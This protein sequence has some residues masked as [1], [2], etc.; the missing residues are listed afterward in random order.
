MK[1]NRYVKAVIY[2]LLNTRLF[3]SLLNVVSP[4]LITVK[5]FN[6]K[7]SNNTKSPFLVAI[8]VDTESGFVN[9]NESRL[10]AN[11]NPKAFQG[12]YHGTNNWREIAKGNDIKITF[13]LCT[14]CFNSEGNE[15]E[16]IIKQLKQAYREG[17][18]IGFHLH[19]KNDYALQKYLDKSL[20]YTSARF[21]DYESMKEML[22]AGRELI[23]ENLGDEIADNV[24]SFRWGNWGL[25]SSAVKALQDTGYKVDTSAC[26]QIKGHQNGEMFYDWSNVDYRYPWI[27]S[28]EDYQSIKEQNSSVIELPIATFKFFNTYFRADPALGSLL[29]NA[30]DYYYEHADRSKKSFV[31]VINSHSSEGTYRNGKPTKIIDTMNK[32]IKHA[33]L[34]DD[35]VF[36]T[37]RDTY[38]KY[39]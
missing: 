31:F 34:F 25:N 18:E 6:N 14:Q 12:Y 35:V 19:P 32:F 39:R 17:H 26:P 28:L 8:T 29:I 5:N 7:F 3:N 11:E 9:S 21:Y 30:F 27:L 33:K 10:W 36:V 15:Y 2:Q 4:Y 24:I 16:K 13:L 23:R 37:L 1:V 38:E 22:N 20:N